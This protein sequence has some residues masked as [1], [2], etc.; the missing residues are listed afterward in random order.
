MFASNYLTYLLLIYF[1]RAY[2]YS[3]G[4]AGNELQCHCGRKLIDYVQDNLISKFVFAVLK[5][6]SIYSPFLFPFSVR[7]IF[8]EKTP[9]RETPWQAAVLAT[10]TTD[11]RTEG[12]V[13]FYCGATIIGPKW[14]LTAAHCLP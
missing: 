13:M 1:P 10:R 14:V 2:E 4:S 9:I 6:R 7:I 5:I 8:G 3:S 12:D 11:P